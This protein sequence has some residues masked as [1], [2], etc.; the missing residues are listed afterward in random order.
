MKNFGSVSIDKFQGKLD[1]D[2]IKHLLSR[3]LF[4]FSPKNITQ[5]S[6]NTLTQA[7]DAIIKKSPTALPPINYY[8]S[9]TKDTTGVALGQTWVNATYGDGTINTRRKISLKA[10]WM[11]LMLNQETTINE[12]M[13]LF[14]QNHFSTELNSYGDA[15]M[16]YKFLEVI[17]KNAL[18]D[19]KSM[20][21]EITLD[22][23]MLLYLNGNSN[24]KT[25][26]DENY[27][28][29]LQEL[30]T[31]GKGPNSKYTES[32]VKM[33][34]KVLT[35]YRV[36]REPV[37]S[38]FDSTKHDTTDKTFSDFFGNKVIKGQSGDAGKNEL[39][40]L[41]T[42][43][44]ATNEVSLYIMRRFYIFFFYYEIT[45]EVEKNFIVPLAKIFKDSNYEILPVLKVMFASKHFFD[46]ELRGCLI[47]S[48]VDHLVGSMKL[49]EPSWPVFQNFIYE[50]Y[51]L[52]NDL[53]AV[54]DKGQQSLL[55]PPNVAGWPAYYQAPVFHEIWINASTLPERAK[56][57]D[58]MVA[59]GLKRNNQAIVFDSF[60]M[61]KKLKKPADP[62]S[63]ISE[64]VFLFF[65]V[66]LSPKLLLDLKKDILLEGQA[67]DYY[68]T[69]I[70]DEAVSKPTNASLA[71][72]TT[73]LKKLITYLMDLPEFQLS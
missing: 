13:I 25:A 45:D 55:D 49:L 61:A 9:V 21:K 41:L 65:H 8:E 17:R 5:F 4:G 27:G 58:N 64:L 73:R 48:P 54:T 16:G 69:E 47:K 30:F 35:G 72:V 66:P 31:L 38:Y 70:W 43:I 3:T 60:S 6:G 23:A 62:N 14:W 63:L 1:D 71:M 12:K 20:V 26:P 53:V 15:R 42:M 36:L 46:L 24:T 7:I 33:A 19:F 32:D 67:S 10:W 39:D 18:G 44:F 56:F 2:A 28:R 22:P 37:S 50:S 52:A 34:A 51:L 57:T 68:W 59:K 11:Q 29:E 40:E